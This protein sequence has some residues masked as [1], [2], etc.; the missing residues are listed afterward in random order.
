MAGSPALSWRVLW[1]A[2]RFLFTI[3]VG[4]A[5]VVVVFRL[6]GRLAGFGALLAFL[7]GFV[8]IKFWLPRSAHKSFRSGDYGRAAFLYRVLG[9]P[10]LSREARASISVSLAACDMARERY[11]D[12]LRRLERI[13]PSR[14]SE[15]ARAAWL[16]N[17]S[18][19]L[20]RSEDQLEAALEYAREAVSLRPDLP[21]FRH[22]RGIA[23]LATGRLDEAI[24]ELDEVWREIAQKQAAPLLEAERCYD[25]A[26]AWATKGEREYA[27]D[28]FERARRAAPDST[29][30]QRA[31]GKLDVNDV[32]LT[33]PLAELV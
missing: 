33:E 10:L 11:D 21:G 3:A 22:T 1:R 4:I 24:R 29:W 2:V 14:L 17:R 9:V 26:V 28:Y 23:L 27:T 15:S 6:F 7:I 32:Q 5:G 8:A 25:L 12:A 19:A 30:G 20:T 18:Y 16:N 31:A 13:E